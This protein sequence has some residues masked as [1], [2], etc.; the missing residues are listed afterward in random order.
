MIKRYSREEVSD[1]WTDQSRFEI[2][3]EVETLALEGM[4]EQGVVPKS[5][6]KSVREKGNF[7]TTRVLE[8]E[9]EVKHDVIAF[10][11]NVAEFVGEDARYLHFGMTSSDLLDTSF[12]VQ[13]TKATDIILQ[14]IDSLLEAIKKRAFEH[15]D[16]L[17]VGRSHGIHAEPITFGLKA[18][19]WYADV[20]RQRDRIAQARK[21]VS[22]GAISGPVGTFAHLS[23]KVEE[24]VCKKLGF[25]PCSVS[26]Q[27]IPR[28][29]HANLFNSFALMGAAI[30]RIAIEVRHLQR[31]EV[32]EAEEFFSKG[33]K[34]SSAMPHKRNPILTENVTGLARLLRSWADCSV[35]NIAL[36]H[37]RD[38][39]HSSVERVIAPDSTI[40][41]DFM[42]H[43]CI[44]IVEGL[45]VYP[46]RMK[47]NLFST[48]GLVYSGS[49]L[50]ALAA[51]GISREDAY[52]MVQSHAM[53]TWNELAGKGKVEKTFEQRV[54]GDSVITDMLSEKELN[55]CLSMDHHVEHVDYIFSRVFK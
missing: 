24:Y 50:V 30:E 32:R 52:K 23:P 34:G 13:L 6:V 16:T 26:T 8:I 5:A 40:T 27:V 54:R 42:I 4:A 46:E 36:W 22:V 38:I 44:R 21:E 10:L 11:T 20:K 48:G 39:S 1:I 7:D 2:W 14:G 47:E 18:A 9:K 35:E 25:E 53:E 29:L 31:T 3:L 28:D 37:E 19:S 15:K 33:Q 43:R 12:A 49:L 41:L 45:V 55:H 51:K 17:C